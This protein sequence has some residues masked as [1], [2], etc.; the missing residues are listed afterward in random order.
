[1]RKLVSLF[2][3]G[4]VALALVVGGIGCSST[5]N[6]VS[7]L[8]TKATPTPT[9][10][11]A[12]PSASA[13]VSEAQGGSIGAQMNFNALSTYCAS[14]HDAAEVATCKHYGYIIVAAP[15]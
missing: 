11:A 12:I 10:S 13:L 14:T 6:P 1:M 4:A 5:S 15:K 7:S 9:P 3:V 8:L 2:S